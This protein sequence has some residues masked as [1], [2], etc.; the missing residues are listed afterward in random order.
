MGRAGFGLEL[1]GDDRHLDL[2]FFFPGTWRQLTPWEDS[3]T[4]GNFQ[5]EQE[6]EDPALEQIFGERDD[7][8]KYINIFV[9]D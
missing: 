3:G 5:L 2:G 8:F 7:I 6:D 9:F 1:D 4:F